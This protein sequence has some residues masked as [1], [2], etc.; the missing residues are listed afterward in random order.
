MPGRHNRDPDG[1]HLEQNRGRS[2]LG[3]TVRRNA[4][5]LDANVG[6]LNGSPVVGVGEHA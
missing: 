1:L 6:L 3:V 5:G 4:T 2:S